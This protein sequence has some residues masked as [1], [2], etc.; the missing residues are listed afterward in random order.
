VKYTKSDTTRTVLYDFGLEIQYVNKGISF[1]TGDDITFS[2]NP[3]TVRVTH[4]GRSVVW[5]LDL[6]GM[7]PEVTYY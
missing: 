4:A 1:I 6:W 2:G 7:Y 5:D 3:A